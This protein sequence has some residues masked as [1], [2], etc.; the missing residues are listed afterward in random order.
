MKTGILITITF[1]HQKIIHF[2]KQ[3]NNKIILSSHR[4]IQIES[5][6]RDKK[7]LSGG[8]ICT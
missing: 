5:N 3:F 1:R 2:I 7:Q 8:K 6:G 4:N